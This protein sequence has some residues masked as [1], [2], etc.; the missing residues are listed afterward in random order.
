MKGVETGGS[1]STAQEQELQ[2]VKEKILGAVAS[3]LFIKDVMHTQ[4]TGIV[5]ARIRYKSVGF[6]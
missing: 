2:K 1:S 4:G 6:C 5:I 3:C